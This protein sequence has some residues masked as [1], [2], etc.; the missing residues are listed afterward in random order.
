MA[1]KARDDITLSR[2]DDGKDGQMIYATSSSAETEAAKIA[3]AS[4]GTPELVPG[5]TLSVK[6]DCANTAANPT[7]NING[8]GAK[9][10]YTQGVPYAYWQAGATVAFMYDG[11]NWRVASEP[12][13]A[14]TVT[15][16]NTTGRNVR[17][18]EDSVDIRSGT[19]ELA[20]FT[21]NKLILGKKSNDAEID[22]CNGNINFSTKTYAETGA[23][24]GQIIAENG[25]V[26]KTQGSGEGNGDG[27]LQIE[28]SR[29]VDLLGP[30]VAISSSN[31]ASMIA[32]NLVTLWGKRIDLGYEEGGIYINGVSLTAYLRDLLY[33]VGSIKMTTVNTNPSTYLGGTWVAWGSGK[34]PVGVNTSE[35]E[36]ATSEKTGGEKTHKLTTAEMPTHRHGINVAGT[37]LDK[38][39]D[40]VFRVSAYTQSSGGAFWNMA[41][42]RKGESVGTHDANIVD[43]GSNGAH[44]NLQPYITCYMWKRT[45]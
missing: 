8:T 42:G 3:T 10:I 27:L 12:V 9:P 35:T 26:I 45:A 20:K 43:V 16:G 28:A 29:M 14:D 40:G 11:A 24:N 21:E 17:I 33:P 13:Y 23:T 44:N 38:N 18:D 5:V 30:Q 36:F 25:L 22:M 32:N 15:V 37:R 34:V 7:L 6:F 31:S 39:Q 1:T 2:V 19:T 41:I 4:S